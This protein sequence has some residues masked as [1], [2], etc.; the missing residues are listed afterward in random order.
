MVGNERKCVRTGEF[1]DWGRAEEEKGERS[2]WWGGEWAG[3][4]GARSLGVHPCI[5]TDN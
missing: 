1:R 2:R 3:L 5:Q 4:T